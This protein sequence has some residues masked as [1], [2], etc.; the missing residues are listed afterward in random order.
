[1][2]NGVEKKERKEEK[3]LGNLKPVSNYLHKTH[4][5]GQLFLQ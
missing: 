3:K 4:L 1:M 5:L 2:L